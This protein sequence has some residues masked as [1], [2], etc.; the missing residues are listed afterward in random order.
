MRR[1]GERRRPTLL[2]PVSACQAKGTEANVSFTSE[3]GVDA[4]NRT[5]TLVAVDEAGR[6]VGERSQSAGSA[7]LRTPSGPRQST[8]GE[9]G[10]GG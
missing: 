1:A 8:P 3:I 2:P 7:R 10:A 5:H 4:H 9:T 6:K